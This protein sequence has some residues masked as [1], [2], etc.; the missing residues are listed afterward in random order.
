MKTTLTLAQL[1]P[2]IELGDDRV[3][4]DAD[5]R[6]IAV[7]VAQYGEVHSGF[8]P[9]VKVP[10]N[11]NLDAAHVG[12]AL[13]ADGSSVKVAVLPMHTPHAPRDLNALHA[14]SWY[15]NSG[16]AVARGRYS[17]DDTGIRFDGVLFDSVNDDQ[18]DRLTA[19][20]FS[21]DWRSAI[22][23]KS[24]GDFENTP[25]DFVGSCL[26][27]I[28]GFSNTYRAAPAERMALVASAQGQSQRFALVASASGNLMSIEDASLTAASIGS[29][30]LSTEDVRQAWQEKWRAD[31]PRP[32]VPGAMEPC[33]DYSW[34]EDVFIV[35]AYIIASVGNEQYVRASWS[36]AADGNIIFGDQQ[37]VERQVNWVTV[38][39]DMTLT[40]G[41][42]CSGDCTTCDGSCGGEGGAADKNVTLTASAAMALLDGTATDEDRKVA[43]EALVASGAIDLE[44]ERGARLDFLEKFAVDSIY[45]RED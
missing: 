37:A 31:H 3:K 14:A 5:T 33:G 7:R 22:A 26:V 43:R 40:A 1:Q 4:V 12:N 45:D 24:F 27:N 19:G 8:G 28:G 38:E 15:E 20:S 39:G 16:T 9:E 18:I 42:G 30:G 44:A 6:Q 10:R 29:E 32:T 41:G 17:E 11:A 21:G 23:I 36:V 34:V 35:P 25:S 2:S 13:L